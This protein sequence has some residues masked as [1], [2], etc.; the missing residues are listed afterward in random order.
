[1]LRGLL[2][3]AVLLSFV[4][5][6]ARLSSAASPGLN[7]RIVFEHIGE[8]GGAQIYSMTSRGT[9]RHLLTRARG[10]RGRS[11]FYSPGGRRILLFRAFK[12]SDLWL[13]GVDGSPKA[14]LT[15][16][17]TTDEADPSW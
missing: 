5:F 9:K 15:R 17:A 4:A 11:P 12:G 14:D 8:S 3:V 6:G 10:A 16:P 2:L 13:N 1:M 7:G